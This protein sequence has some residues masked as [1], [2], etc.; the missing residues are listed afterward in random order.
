MHVLHVVALTW[1]GPDGIPTYFRNQIY[2]SARVIAV[3]SVVGGGFGAVLGH[4]G[5][6]SLL[7][8]NAANA[9]RAVPTLALL[10]LLATWPPTSIPWNGLLAPFLALTVL[11]VPPILTNAYVGVREVDA[12][13]TDA[14]RAM[15][16]TGWQV[17]GR[18]ELPLALPF[19]MA[20][21][22]TAAVEVVATS[23]LAA[24]TGYSDLGTPVLAGLNSGDNTEALYGALLVAGTAALVALILGVVVRLVT[25]PAL[26]RKRRAWG[27]LAS[28]PVVDAPV[29]S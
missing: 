9:F 14:A 25:P 8:V 16:Y 10:T 1:S 19:L 15:G 13:I 7:A 2:L 17:M 6:G 4:T 5:R 24:Y 18:V 29:P 12:D 21:I 28:A 11:A 23:T 3:A 27:L 20:G 22:R 26:R